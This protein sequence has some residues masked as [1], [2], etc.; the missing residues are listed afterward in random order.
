MGDLQERAK[1]RLIMLDGHFAHPVRVEHVEEIGSDVYLVRVRHANGAPDET[2]V[3]EAELEAALAQSAVQ[4]ALVSSQDLFLWVESQRIRLAFAHDPLFA[5]SM[6][7]VRGLPHQ[8]EAVYR[9][10]LP[11]PRLRFVLADDPGAGKTIMAGLLLK[12]LKLRGVVE[13]VLILCPA[14]LTTQWQDEMLDKFDEQFEVVSGEQVRHQVGRSPWERYPLIVSSLDFAKRDD[15]RDDLL[16]NQWDLVIVDEAHKASAFTKRGQDERVVK[17]KRYSVVEGV[18]QQADRL[19]LLTATPHSGDEDRFTRFLGL[20]DPDQF[21]TADLVKK[22]IANDDNPYFLRRQKEDLVDEHNGAL[23]VERH[24]RTQPFQLSPAE[25]ELYLSVTQYVNTYLGASG[26]SRGNAVALARTVLQRRLASSLGAIRSSLAKRANRLEE[27]AEQLAGMRPADRNRRLAALGRIP[28]DSDF[29]DVE[30]ESDDIDETVDD[31]LATEVSSAGQISQLRVEVAELRK[32]VAHADRVRS[33][34][35][36]RKLAALRDCLERAEFQELRDGRGKLLIFTEHRDTLEYLRQH[37]EEWGY[38]VCT[39]HGGHPPAERKRIQHDF[40]QNK[41]ICIATEAAG[42]GINLQFCHLMINYDLPWNPVRLEQRMGRVHR[43]GQSADCWIFNFCATNTV[44]GELLERLHARLEAMRQDLNGRVYDVIGELLTIN[45]IDFERLVKETLANPTRANRD[46]AVA[47][48]NRLDSE[49]LAEYEEATGIALAKKYVD[50]EWVRGQNFLSDERRLM[51][52]YV[53]EFFLRAA[54]RQHLR[55]ERRADQLLRVEHVPAALRSDDLLSVRHRGRPAADY[56]K[57]TFRKE[58]RDRVEHEDATLCSPGHP[59][60]AALAES[61]ERDLTAEGVPQG[62]AVFIDPGTAAPYFVHLFSYQIVGEDLHGS[63]EQ[64][65][66]EVVAVIEDH[67]GLHRGPADVLHTLTPS[68]GDNAEP[69][70]PDQIKLAT[71]WLRVKVQLPRTSTERT[72]RLEHA[73]LR[74][75]YLNEAMAAQKRRLEDR[76]V[77]Y[78]SKIDAGDDSYRLLR[79]NTDRQ[80]K[81]LGHR[82]ASKLE[83]LNRLGVVRPGKVTHLGTAAVLPPAAP[84]DPD[85]DVMRPS[86]AVEDA[87]VAVAMEFERE[88]GWTPEYVGD[89]RDGSGFDIRSTRTLPDGS[90]EVRRIEVKGRGVPAGDVGLYRTEWYAAQRWGAGFWLYVVYSATSRPNLLRVQDPYHTLPNVAAIRQITGY[91]VPG[92]S[93][94]AHA[95]GNTETVGRED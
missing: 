30:A 33:Q 82:R 79:D 95:V 8:I 85:V 17:T 48:I 27:L 9:H 18:A 71:D 6:S 31:L 11:Q 68:A 67:D 37:L 86:K 20:L 55:V 69:P 60:F 45:G 57:L 58:Q 62:A 88:A 74:A 40:R 10:M 21:S 25:Y 53:E 78:N 59:L 77:S 72:N 47:E 83:S 94:R 43:I 26:G 2:Q 50:I 3:F 56:R 65:F 76:W 73:R 16:R 4:P 23:F 84:D 13:R 80:L 52:E 38:D 35:E 42:E 63:P 15:V 36:E 34:G 28:A 41:Q 91:R 75:T 5:V 7:G 89:L 54:G 14:P 49:K 12:E 64:V 39:I 32:L 70:S 87:A 29:D 51:P 66:S 46:A 81:E 19:L 92:A 22:Q 44:E 93:I 1:N 61:L 90:S 24:V